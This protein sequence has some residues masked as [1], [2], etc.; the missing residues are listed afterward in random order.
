MSALR[1]V[2]AGQDAD[3]DAL[4]DRT[5]ADLEHLIAH[6]KSEGSMRSDRW[7]EDIF[8]A[9]TLNEALG[10]MGHRDQRSASLRFL[11]LTVASLAADPAP[12]E[13]SADEPDAILALRRTLGH[14]LAG[15]PRLSPEAAT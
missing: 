6:A 8:L 1:A 10:A 11:E 15:L 12:A 14:D 5:V 3:V 13:S 2:P 7:I 4:R 9:L